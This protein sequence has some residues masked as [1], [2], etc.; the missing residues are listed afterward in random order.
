MK[1]PT[2]GDRLRKSREKKGWSQTY[3]C[4]KLGLSNSALSGYERNY[5]EPDA[6]TLSQL[7]KLYE[8]SVDYLING[9]QNPIDNRYKKFDNSTYNEGNGDRD[10]IAGLGQVIETGEMIMVPIIAGIACGKPAYAEDEIL[11]YLPMG[12]ALLS[13]NPRDYVFLR[14][15]GDSMTGADIQDGSFVL[16]K[17]QPTADNGDIVA[18]CI[19]DETAT[20]KRIYYHGDMVVLAAENPKYMPQTYHISEVRVVGKAVMVT[21][22]L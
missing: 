4:R 10:W 15:E 9:D 13:G 12:T 11:G 1:M 6:E 14:A 7:A 8:V 3:V 17:K 5:R 2:L 20:L 18:V 19:H 21:K 22:T 16:I